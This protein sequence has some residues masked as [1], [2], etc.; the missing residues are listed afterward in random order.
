MDKIRRAYEEGYIEPGYIGWDDIQD[1][2]ARG[3][4][5]SLRFLKDRYRMISDVEAEMGWWACFDKTE[6]APRKKLQSAPAA[7]AG[8][9]LQAVA[10]AQ[11]GR[12]DPCPCG[13]GKKFK[14]CCGG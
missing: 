3:K 6:A 11:A 13:S 9:I 7:P 4:E 10:A 14:K 1:A 2:L 12:N 5:A 8:V